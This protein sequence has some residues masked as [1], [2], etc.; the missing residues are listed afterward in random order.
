MKIMSHG[1]VPKCAVLFLAVGLMLI[2]G[3]ASQQPAQQNASPHGQ[4]PPAGNQSPTPQPPAEPQA[5]NSTGG[6]IVAA[7]A[8][9]S[10]TAP[11]IKL[12]SS[13]AYFLAVD[14][15]NKRFIDH[16][17]DRSIN[18]LFINGTFYR[19]TNLS[20]KCF[21]AGHSDD[22]Y[23]IPDTSAELQLLLF[24]DITN[25]TL[26]R[27][28]LTGT[29]LEQGNALL[30]SLEPAGDGTLRSGDAWGPLANNTFISLGGHYLGKDIAF[31][32]SGVAYHYS[33]SNMTEISSADMDGL[34]QDEIRMWKGCTPLL[35]D[36]KPL[37]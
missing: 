22:F 31:N 25:N 14:F 24:V 2:S 19:I 20:G 28:N 13:V 21:I 8:L 26:Q 6:G 1:N 27:A 16:S 9:V 5:Q 35:K 32:D 36:M 17:A 18:S 3:C 12:N 10:T 7:D 29:E 30:G 15:G 4:S 34:V 11:S 23:H 37:Q 33:Y